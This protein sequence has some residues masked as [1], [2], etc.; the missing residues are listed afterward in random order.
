MVSIGEGPVSAK[1]YK[2]N[3]QPRVDNLGQRGIV[4]NV[5]KFFVLDGSNPFLMEE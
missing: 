1:K 5:C 4:G 3:K 2:Y